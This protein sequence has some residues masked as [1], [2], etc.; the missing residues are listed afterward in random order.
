M[1]CPR[2][3][4]DNDKVL[5]SRQSSSG[6]SI[7]RRRECLSCSYRFTS[8]ERIEEQPLMVVKR[9]GIRETFDLT[10]IS[11]G[12]ERSLEKRPVSAETV[13]EI[14]THIEDQAYM[15]GKSTHEVMAAEL[16]EIVL[17]KLYA[18]DN[19]AYI[20]FASVYRKYADVQE[21]IDE[22]KKLKH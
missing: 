8:Y 15:I 4:E 11:R 12:L 6:T 18:I 21:F 5:E 22:I 9:S 10:K 1:R 17:E 7:R 13:T 2:C 14:L 3:G 20:R 19:V 16:G